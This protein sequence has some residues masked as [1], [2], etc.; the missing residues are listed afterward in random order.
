LET[1]SDEA[2]STDSDKEIHTITDTDT[3][4]GRDEDP[5]YAS[6]SQVHV[7]SRP[8]DTLNSGGVYPS[9]GLR[10]QEAPHVNK[11]STT[12]IILSPSS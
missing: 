8:Q 11:D 6:D 9:S 12:I 3:N 1:D 10:I 2:S 7:S 5:A 4:R